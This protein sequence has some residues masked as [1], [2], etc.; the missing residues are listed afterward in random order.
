MSHP[1]SQQKIWKIV[2]VLDFKEGTKAAKPGTL[3]VQSFIGFLFTTTLCVY[4][5]ESQGSGWIVV[6]FD[7][8][9]IC[10]GAMNTLEGIAQR[11][12]FHRVVK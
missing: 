8:C 12:L 3:D 6:C 7:V 10:R 5:L 2:D 9:L 11:R 4:P 1:G